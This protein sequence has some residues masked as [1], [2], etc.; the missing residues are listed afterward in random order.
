MKARPYL[1]ASA[2]EQIQNRSQV[3]IGMSACAAQTGSPSEA[4]EV[5]SWMRQ[6]LDGLKIPGKVCYLDKSRC[7]SAA[8]AGS[9]PARM[10][11][12]PAAKDCL[13]KQSGSP[14]VS[15][16]RPSIP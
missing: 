12:L 7:I 10:R 15:I 16:P 11:D 5:L 2:L 13:Q 9:V 1:S 4:F 8:S 14:V 3:T 6:V